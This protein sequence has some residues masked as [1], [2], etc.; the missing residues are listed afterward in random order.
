MS[1]TIALAAVILVG[2]LLFAGAY[3]GGPHY[4]R[5]SDRWRGR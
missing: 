1:E 5:W 3:L 4:R 2:G